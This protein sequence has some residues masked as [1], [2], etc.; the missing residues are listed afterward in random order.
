VS[1]AYGLLK[2]DMFATAEFNPP[3]GRPAIHVPESAVHELRGKTVVFVQSASGTFSATEIQ[4]G[5][6]ADGQI[7]VVSGLK[8]GTPVVTEGGLLLKSQM[9]KTAGE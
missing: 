6:R 2:P 7:R 3:P 1:N 8:A 9:L 4:I 5:E